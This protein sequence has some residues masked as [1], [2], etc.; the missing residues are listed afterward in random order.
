MKVCIIDYGLGN[1]TSVFNAVEKL[2]FDV[3]ISNNIKEIIDS[4]HLILP[5][6]GS[7][8]NGMRN[9]KN[10]NLVDV[11]TR[12]VMENKKP[13]LGICLGMQILASF[14]YEHG[15]C[16]GL[17]FIKGSVK[18]LKCNL[19]SE[20]IPHIGWND[21]SIVRESTLVS[22]ITESLVFYFVHSYHFTPE[23]KSIVTGMCDYTGGFVSIIENENIFATQFHP[24][25]SHDVGLKLIENF[26]FNSNINV[27]N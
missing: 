1:L 22:G 7:F 23:D 20:K 19:K 14:G 3:C 10:L 2:G 25:K 5:G 26:L 16:N 24:E 27:K 21:V 13:I 18:R 17:G 15:G 6:V 4:T 12:E 9:L 8:S 11:L